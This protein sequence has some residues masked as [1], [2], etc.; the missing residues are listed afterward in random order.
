MK[1]AK[2][3]LILFLG[4]AV[5]IFSAWSFTV[6]KIKQTLAARQVLEKDQEKLKKM[7]EKLSDLTT[8]DEVKLTDKTRIA[9][10]AV[11][12][13]KNFMDTLTVIAKIA[14]D[15]GLVLSGFSI[16]PGDLSITEKGTLSYKLFVSGN[17]ENL[18]AFLAA[19][20]KTLPLVAPA[21]NLNVDMSGAS[22]EFDMSTESYFL[23]LPKTLGTIDSPVPKLTSQEE[24]VLAVI[25][26]F[27]FVPQ[28]AVTSSG[29]KVNPFSF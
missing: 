12:T 9:L 24:E 2:A 7:N 10:R 5:L 27:T 25:S 15:N 21:G 19:I 28:M 23:P 11:S 29:G 3:S 16:N 22:T 6:P 20:N 8:L 18:V 14:G 4:V 1:D 26:G 13:D 17:K